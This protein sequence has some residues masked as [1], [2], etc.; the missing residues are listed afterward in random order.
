[1]DSKDIIYSEDRFGYIL[2]SS[3]AIVYTYER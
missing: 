3:N 2:S 1:M